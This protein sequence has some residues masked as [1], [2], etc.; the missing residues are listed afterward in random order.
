MTK[1]VYA[2]PT[3]ELG[4]FRCL[5]KRSVLYDPLNFSETR[6]TGVQKD[7]RNTQEHGEHTL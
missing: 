6:N 2:V 7:A 5:E 3:S 1:A 4:I